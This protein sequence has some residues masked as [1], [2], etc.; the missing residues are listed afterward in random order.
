MYLR[1]AH[2]VR[3]AH[4][5]RMQT[6]AISERALKLGLGQE[7]NDGRVRLKCM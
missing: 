5:G 2:T 4:N 7:E 6:T 3:V 1:T